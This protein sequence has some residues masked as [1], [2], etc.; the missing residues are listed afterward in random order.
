MSSAREG[1]AS[2]IGDRAE[3]LAGGVGRRPA[4]EKRR[5]TVETGLENRVAA[6][7]S[8]GERSSELDDRSASGLGWL[9]VADGVDMCSRA[10]EERPTESADG[11]EEARE[12]GCG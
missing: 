2:A 12:C 1:G 3:R 8:A 7:K 4:E 5:G 9:C 10:Q 11:A 6:T